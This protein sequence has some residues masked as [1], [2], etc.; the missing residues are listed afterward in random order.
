MD[1]WTRVSIRNPI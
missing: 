1:K